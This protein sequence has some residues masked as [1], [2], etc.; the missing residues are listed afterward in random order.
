MTHP[1]YA[2][3]LTEKYLKFTNYVDI[4][5]KASKH[6]KQKQPRGTV[7]LPGAA[8]MYG[9][10]GQGGL[11]SLCLQLVVCLVC[12]KGCGGEAVVLPPRD[13]RGNGGDASG[14]QLLHGLALDGQHGFAQ[15]GQ[16]LIGQGQQQAG[17]AGNGA[18]GDGGC[19]VGVLD[20]KSV[21]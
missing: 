11:L 8:A 18:C 14:D 7:R 10:F 13:Q 12:L 1:F 4:R 5:R 21:V 20:R 15:C 3:T 17:G 16:H 19:V 9:Y 2:S 6:A